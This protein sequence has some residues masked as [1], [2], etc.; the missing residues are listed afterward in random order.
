MSNYTVQAGD[1]LSKIAARF[2]SSVARI[3]ADNGIDDP[4]FIQVGQVLAINAAAAPV[5]VDQSG[6]LVTTPGFPDPDPIMSIGT[7]IDWREWL[8]PPRVYYV[9]AA[10]AVVVYLL[11]KKRR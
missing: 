9:A 1:T 6:A 4:D 10:A 3:A 2:G 8:K 7:R 5:T 11:T